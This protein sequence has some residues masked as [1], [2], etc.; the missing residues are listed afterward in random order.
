M[1]DLHKIVIPKIMNNWEYVAEAFHYDLA[2]I[3][4]IKEDGFWD[5]RQCCR[6]FFKDWLTTDHGAKVGPK[7]WS[8]LLGILKQID[9]I[10]DYI[11]E[12]IVMKVKQIKSD[13][14]YKG[15][16]WNI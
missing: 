15:E 12:D 7:M 6:E 8:T 11:T 5:P 4:A 13:F 10:P 16:L 1:F 14:S 9:E 3:E 2:R